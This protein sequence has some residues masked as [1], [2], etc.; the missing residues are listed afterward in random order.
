MLLRILHKACQHVRVPLKAL[1]H[2]RVWVVYNG[3]ERLG[4]TTGVLLGEANMQVVSVNVGLPRAVSWKGRQV[5]TGIFKEPVHGAVRVRT[6]NFDGD[7]QADLRV[8]GG[9]EK[10][11]YAY[12]AEHYP[13]W[14]QELPTMDLPL[15]VFGENLTITGLQERLVNIGDR[16]RI[17]SCELVVT[18]PRMPCYKLGLRFGRDDM[19]K[20]FLDSRRCG[21]YFAVAQEGELAA[22]DAVTLIH[23]DPQNI[24]V[25]DIVEWYVAGAPN[26]ESLRRA[27]AHEGL[28]EMWRSIFAQQL[29][30]NEERGL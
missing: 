15:G 3:G 16:F 26:A 21:V 5:A 1:L 10:A 9:A 12:G 28:P 7:R 30:Q 4:S 14:Q 20:R 19:L 22:G 24:A 8:H 27:V 13:F 11:V 6:L 2:A 29:E 18:Q 17:G 25:T 23:R